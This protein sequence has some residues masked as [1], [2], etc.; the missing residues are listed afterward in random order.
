MA[1]HAQPRPRTAWARGPAEFAEVRAP[2]ANE[3]KLSADE[4]RHGVRHNIFPS[5]N[6]D[7]IVLPG[8]AAPVTTVQHAMRHVA[9]SVWQLGGLH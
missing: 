1:A 6:D 4:I 5:L 7:E 3:T 2:D 9:A 8:G